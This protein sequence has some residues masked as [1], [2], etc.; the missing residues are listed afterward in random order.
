[1]YRNIRTYY[2]YF[3]VFCGTG[4]SAV[5]IYPHT[6][7]VS[8]FKE[9]ITNKSQLDIQV[10]RLVEEIKTDLKIHTKNPFNVNKV[11]EI[12]PTDKIDFLSQGFLSM[13]W[14]AVIGIPNYFSSDFSKQAKDN[15]DILKIMGIEGVNEKKEQEILETFQL[16]EAA[17]KYA[18]AKEISML[19][20]GKLL[21]FSF[22]A[23]LTVILSYVTA[24]LFSSFT[25][26][27]ITYCAAQ[28]CLAFLCVGIYN[29]YNCYWEKACDLDVASINK[30]LALGG[31]EYY[32]ALLKRQEALGGKPLVANGNIFNQYMTKLL[33]P[34]LTESEK[35]SYLTEVV[36]QKY[37]R[38]LK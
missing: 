4:V 33:K 30:D 27:S 20:S 31:I 11:L 6:L 10:L 29:Y 35:L 8:S 36:E 24:R 1:M 9:K 13:R 38:E 26:A 15:K 21:L 2:P 28:S 5:T 37:G 14:G 7:G 16:S 32:T 22:A 23:G 3:W 17:K 18:L 25:L 19:N 34:A 12:V